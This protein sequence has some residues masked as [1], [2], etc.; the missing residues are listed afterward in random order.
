MNKNKKTAEKQ[1]AAISP[2]VSTIPG[3]PLLQLSMSDKIYLA[4]SKYTKDNLHYIYSL[5]CPRISPAQT[6]YS[7]VPDSE[8]SV[9]KDADYADMYY[10][11][12]M[13]IKD[14]QSRGSGYE[15]ISGFAKVYIDAFN[16]KSR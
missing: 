16:K 5:F 8:I 4:V 7:M 2:V 6:Q 15:A 1:E 13:Q 11:T 3:L 14:F 10:Q 9:F 12:L